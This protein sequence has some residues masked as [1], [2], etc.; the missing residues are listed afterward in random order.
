MVSKNIDLGNGLE[1]ESITVGKLH[2]EPILKN[3]T[4]GKH[5]AGQEFQEIKPMEWPHLLRVMPTAQPACSSK[6]KTRAVLQSSS[7]RWPSIQPWVPS[8]PSSAAKRSVRRCIICKTR[9]PA[10]R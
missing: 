3:A 4:L 8:T 9:W 10:S 7:R 2:F 6:P 5:F 1:F